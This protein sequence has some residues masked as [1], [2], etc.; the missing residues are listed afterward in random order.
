MQSAI[1][2]QYFLMDRTL[3]SVNFFNATIAPDEVCV[4]EVFRIQASTPL[5]LDDHLNRL[6][7]SLKTAGKVS[8]VRISM[9]P[10]RLQVLYTANNINDGNV[11]LDL[12]FKNNGDAYFLAYFIPARYPNEAERKEGIVCTLQYDERTHPT[13]KIYNASIRNKANDII[14]QEHVYET[15]LVNHRHALT[16]GSRSNLFFI[17]DD[18]LITAKEQEVLPGIMRQQIINC[19][20]EL[21]I[22]IVYRSLP[23]DELPVMEAAFISGTSPRLLPI[24]RIDEHPFQANHPLLIRLRDS[25]EERIT[26]QLK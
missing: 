9:L 13:A 18:T 17:K 4:Y 14:A 6:T 12:R 5:F 25:L 26:M 3:K 10:R 24:R 21:K 1:R 11:K 8:P 23:M 19:A 7:H 2:G 22:K 20:L 15:L 16:E